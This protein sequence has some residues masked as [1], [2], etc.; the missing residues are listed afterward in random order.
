MNRADS[1]DTLRM[2]DDA[3]AAFARPDA[4]RTRGERD[5]HHGFDPAVW[6]EMAAMGW[7]AASL[8]ERQGGLGLGVRAG[9]A[10]ARRLGYA[11][12][13][14]PFVAAG[15][16]VVECLASCG[17][18]VRALLA[19]V[20]A[21]R[22]VAGMAWQCA[23]GGAGMEASA[24]TASQ[25][26]G[27]MVLA[28]VC[29]FVEVPDA[30]VFIVAARSSDGPCLYCVP[31][32]SRGVVI[33]KEL[34]ADGTQLARIAF[35]DLA[36][37][38][39]SLVAQGTAATEAMQRAVTAGTLATSAELLGL[40]ERCLDLTLEY[41]KTR[42][43]FGQ[44]IGAFQALQH[45]AVDMWIQKQLTEAALRSALD[46]FDDPAADDRARM[47][48]ASSV[49]SRASQAALYVCGQ[50]VQLHG[51]IGFTDECELGVYVNRGLALA[52]RYG[53]AAWHRRRYGELT[54]V[55]FH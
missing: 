54:S 36:L 43:Q 3:V 28:G 23:N 2:L 55:E 46:V 5:Q 35:N 50:A 10:I 39:T 15:L 14:A 17:S 1:D 32:A 7:L 21:G 18:D 12:Y 38:P 45:R 34:A 13:Q 4:Q 40:M 47:L 29:R 24:V 31:Q 42:Q 52:A 30:D 26:A 41:L 44:P 11:G 37:E 25:Q 22:Q 6:R 33:D 16:M 51:A 49:K 20:L 53:N 19:S 8:P 9:A 27:R 48:A